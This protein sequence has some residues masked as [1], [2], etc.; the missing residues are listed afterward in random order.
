MRPITVSFPTQ[1][2]NEVCAT[3]ATAASGTTLVINGSYSQQI[4]GTVDLS[5]RFVRLP[6]YTQPISVFSSGN[7]S[8]STFTFTGLDINGNALTTTIAGPTGTA[9]PTKTTSE[10]W[11]VFTASIG[12]T[13][14][15]SPFTIGF[16][17]SGSTNAAV[18][19]YFSVP[20]NVTVALVKAA[21]SG[22]VTFQH[23]FDNLQTSTAP[24]WLTMTFSSGVSLASLTAATTVT[25]AES[26]YAVRAILLAT[27]A[28]T[29][30]VQ[31]TFVQPGT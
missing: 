19:S 24:T 10:F 11:T 1:V 14:A 15:S 28:A 2:Q 16:G 5:Q 23:T 22:P 6:G 26:P 3:N 8:T 13:L 27:A 30:V 9:I 25:V 31:V 18:M 20:E 12:A 4:Q 17:P 21:T 7:I 29:G